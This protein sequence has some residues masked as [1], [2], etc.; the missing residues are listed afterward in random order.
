MRLGVIFNH[1]SLLDGDHMIS[2]AVY[3]ALQTLGNNHAKSFITKLVKEENVA[4]LK[5]GIKTLED[6]EVHVSCIAPV[7]CKI[8]VGGMAKYFCR[9]I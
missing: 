1:V 4:D 3:T 2:K 7:L 9:L 6:L 8:L 5:S